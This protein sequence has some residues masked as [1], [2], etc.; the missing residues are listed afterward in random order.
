MRVPVTGAG[1]K[2]ATAVPRELSG[3]A[4]GCEVF[5]LGSEHSSGE[6]ALDK[7]KKMPGYRPT[8]SFE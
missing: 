7:A 6:S 2:V 3:P 4:A 1:G 8:W 5:H